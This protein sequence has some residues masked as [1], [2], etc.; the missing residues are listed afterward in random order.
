MPMAPL[1]QWK[2]PAHNLLSG[3]AAMQGESSMAT[4]LA[5][6]PRLHIVNSGL[7]YKLSGM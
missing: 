7:Y 6:P 4:I 2:P 5:P 3:L 1:V